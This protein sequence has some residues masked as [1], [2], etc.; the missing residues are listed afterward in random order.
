ML[1]LNPTA[2]VLW[3][4]I[5]DT[6]T[7]LSCAGVTEF[8]QGGEKCAVLWLSNPIFC[9]AINRG[10]IV[11]DNARHTLAFKTRKSLASSF[12]R[13][14]TNTHENY[15]GRAIQIN[16]VFV[17][18]FLVVFMKKSIIFVKRIFALIYKLFTAW[19]SFLP[20]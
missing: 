17:Q 16:P 2:P 7:Y 10:P 18:I 11:F 12:R 5:P 9:V 19:Y 8:K 14:G 1:C 13:S 15:F 4:P 6:H 3:P 20:N